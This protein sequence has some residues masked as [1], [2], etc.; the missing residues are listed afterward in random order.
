MT[1][2]EAK[3]DEIAPIPEEKQKSVESVID[4]H[5]LESFRRVW[6]ILNGDDPDAIQV[7]NKIMDLDSDEERSNFPT[8]LTTL[9]N[10]QAKIYARSTFKDGGWNPFDLHASQMSKSHMGYKGFKSTQVT[11]IMRTTQDLT[12]LEAKPEEVKQSIRQRIF[13][14][15]KE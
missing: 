12:G 13:G 7:I 5:D 15:N 4:F 9:A 2:A 6:M 3:K 10:M 1:E 8:I 11:D 14:G